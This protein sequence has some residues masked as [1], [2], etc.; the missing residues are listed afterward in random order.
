MR[1]DSASHARGP[2]AKSGRAFH[3][4]IRSPDRLRTVTDPS[5]TSLPTLDEPGDAELISAVRAGDLEA[6]GTLFERHV[7]AARRLARQLVSAGDV[8]DLVSDAFSKVLG[9]LQKGGGP[10]LAFRA[11]L[12]TSLRRLHVDKIRANSRLTPTDDLTPYD[13]GVPFE[14]TA[15]SGFDNAAAAK[16]FAAL[17]ERWQQ[18]LW[19]TEVEG[20]KPAEI[21]PLL[22]MS[23]NSVSALAYRARE[24]LRQ[25]FISMHAQ[26]ALDDA[27]ARTRANLGAYIR[28]GLSK[29]DSGKVEAHLQE[30]RECT[31]I[32]LELTEVNS[33][34][35]AIL[36]PLLLG[37]A[38]AGYLAAASGGTKLGILLFLSHAKNWVLHNPVGRVTAGASG[39]AVAA[40]VVAAVAMTGGHHPP[41]HAA[42]KPNT[43]AAPPAAGQQPPASAPAKKAPSTSAPPPAAPAA[44]PAAPPASAPPT[45]PSSTK[46]PARSPEKA[47]VIK[48]PLP[49]VSAT[50]GKSVLIDLTNG[51]TDPNGDPL[52]VKSASVAEPAH[53]TVRTGTAKA[54]PVM[55]RIS[56]G[57]TG[58]AGSVPLMARRPT[59]PTT[60]T[61]TPDPGWRGT[62]TID[63]TL[64]DGHGG[65][66]SGTVKV[67]TPDT[68]PVA[69][70][71]TKAVD[72]VI[73]AGKSVTIDALANDSDANHDRLMIEKIATAPRYGSA[74]TNGRTITYTPDWARWADLSQPDTFRYLISDGHGGTATASVTVT[75]QSDA[76]LRLE[77]APVG[78]HQHLRLTAAG[79]PAAHHAKVTFTISGIDRAVPFLAHTS[80]CQPADLED[81]TGSITETCAIKDGEVFHLDFVPE[82]NWSVTTSLQPTGFAD[83]NL[84]NDH[85]SASGTWPPTLAWPPPQH[86]RGPWHHSPADGG[87]V[88]PSANPTAPTPTQPSAADSDVPQ[89]LVSSAPVQAPSG[90][91]QSEEVQAGDSETGDAR[92]NGDG[93]GESLVSKVLHALPFL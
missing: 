4:T 37:G 54:R 60:V 49:T 85:P 93:S 43:P 8:D 31:A 35:G 62:D 24:G 69:R 40:V 14:D 82:S 84:A 42:S 18:V 30:C 63:Y 20:Q 6:Y 56:G 39:V 51:A 55:P 66:V 79:I 80:A 17:P 29:R 48:T 71:D 7:E 10:D 74:T 27:C 46:P 53:G 65:T 73:T 2:R 44:V 21:A 41:P 86:H 88:P 81:V 64:T 59:G 5:L 87:S 22:G 78:I 70:H 89:P 1:G 23:P 12:L 75:P 36:A 33:N 92:T 25:A 76:S 34:L 58:V 90:A 11:Y 19:H 16:A 26:E 91:D 77:A 3:I 68:A 72:Y 83:P 57:K 15:V 32:Y 67:T 38:G 50:P 9:V 45:T 47:P 13:P 52:T 61:Y 28:G